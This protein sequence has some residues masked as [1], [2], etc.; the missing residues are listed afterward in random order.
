MD[1]TYTNISKLEVTTR[2]DGTHYLFGAFHLQPDGSLFRQ[3]SP[4]RLPSKELAALR[5]L[6]QHAGQI[7]SPAQLRSAIWG[8]VHVTADSLPRCISSLR[9]VLESEDCIQTI[10]K[11][12]YRFML[13]VKQEEPEPYKGVERRRVRSAGCFLIANVRYFLLY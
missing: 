3:G 7:V 13:P 9:A 12:G 10:Y 11:R 6:L 8:A 2:S 4:V 5:V 1:M